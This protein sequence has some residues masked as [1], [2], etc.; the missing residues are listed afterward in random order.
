MAMID[1]L[2]E[3]Q[4]AARTSRQSIRLDPD[5][6]LQNPLLNTQ[7]NKVLQRIIGLF[8]DMKEN[9]RKVN[10]NLVILDQMGEALLKTVDSASEK[11]VNG[12][13]KRIVQANLDFFNKN[14]ELITVIKTVVQS[15]EAP[16]VANNKEFIEANFR[17]LV[18]E[19]NRVMKLSLQKESDFE[20]KMKSRIKRELKSIDAN[21]D[22][23]QLAEIVEDP[24]KVN[25]VLQ[26]NLLG[27]V[28]MQ[29]QNYLRD[30][31]EKYNDIL[32][33]EKVG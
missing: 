18:E 7:E 31:K 17:N 16:A 32:M 28:H 3:L 12:A 26:A 5:D 22:D 13:M 33:L 24:A 20:A 1:R 30:V 21:L 15:D 4:R 11:Q 8:D 14:K 2:A 10:E 25:Q 19:N 27:P 9:L 29:V 6:H 23:Q